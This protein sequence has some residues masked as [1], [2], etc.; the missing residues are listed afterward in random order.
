M[1]FALIEKEVRCVAWLSVL[2]RFW[3]LFRLDRLCILLGILH[4]RAHG[5]PAVPAFVFAED[6]VSS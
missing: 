5:W 6:V 2:W 4:A 3:Y 1:L